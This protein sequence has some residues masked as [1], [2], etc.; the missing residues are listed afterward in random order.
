MEVLPVLKGSQA[1]PIRG[2]KSLVSCRATWSPNGE[3][4]P[5]TM[6]P[7]CAV[8][9]PATIWPLLELIC[10]AFA[11]TNKAESKPVAWP[12]ASVGWLNREYLTPYVTVRFGFQRKL[13]CAYSSHW[14]C[15]I[16]AWK[17]E[18]FCVND[19]TFPRRKFAHSWSS[20]VAFPPGFGF[21]SSKEK[22]PSF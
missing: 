22:V 8:P 7:F 21:V 3:L 14:C 1:R 6:M 15:R 5:P 17:S 9:V 11:G 18:L 4:C 16:S 13:S 19:V 12:L 2:P 20:V 10:G